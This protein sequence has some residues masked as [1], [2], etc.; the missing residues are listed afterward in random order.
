MRGH[1]RVVDDRCQIALELRRRSD[2]ASV[3]VF[4]EVIEEFVSKEVRD[5]GSVYQSMNFL[6]AAPIPSAGTPTWLTGLAV[7]NL[8]GWDLGTAE[9]VTPFLDL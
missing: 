1:H 8:V 3:A 2:G 5:L 7:K 9:P 4:E 6:R